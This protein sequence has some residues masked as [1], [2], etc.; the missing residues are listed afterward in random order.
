MSQLLFPHTLLEFI[1]P[2][3]NYR[4]IVVL[5][6]YFS[7]REASPQV[8]DGKSPGCIYSHMFD[9]HLAKRLAGSMHS[10]HQPGVYS[11]RA[12]LTAPLDIQQEV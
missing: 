8:V 2:K 6:L 5:V 3:I 9:D 11:S 7:E 4:I 1:G 10:E 12:S